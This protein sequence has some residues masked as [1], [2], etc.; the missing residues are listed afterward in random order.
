MASR[1]DQAGALTG[2]TN[3]SV[4]LDGANDNVIRNPIAGVGTTAIS[5][6]FWLKTTDTTK[7]RASS[8]TPRR[9]RRT[10]S[11]SATRARCAVYVKGTAVNTGVE[12]ERRRRGTTSP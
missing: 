3:R 1:L 9:R 4:L 12:A 5:T 10:S 11:S 8:R 6:D 2:D 7:E